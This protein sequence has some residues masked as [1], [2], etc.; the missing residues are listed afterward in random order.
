MD[1]SIERASAKMQEERRLKEIKSAQE[2]PD[3]DNDKLQEDDGSGVS[4][5]DM[6]FL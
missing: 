3:R 5:E 1:D 4:V 6:V 2:K